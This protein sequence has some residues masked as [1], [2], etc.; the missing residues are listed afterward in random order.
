MIIMACTTCTRDKQK[1]K[2]K[3]DPVEP[4]EAS[5]N[6]NTESDTQDVLCLC[7]EVDPQMSEE[8]PHL[9][10]GIAEELHQALLPRDVQSTEQFITECC[11]VE[12]LRCSIRNKEE[13]ATPMNGG[14]LKESQSVSTA[15]AQVTSSAIAATR[16]DTM[17]RGE[18]NIS[19]ASA[20]GMEVWCHQVSKF[21]GK[22]NGLL[23][24]RVGHWVIFVY[25]DPTGGWERHLESWSNGA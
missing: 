18:M 9:M 22:K 2:R 15:N 8:I 6:V 19:K 21:L 7:K 16:I 11:R 13:Y 10:K 4:E 24:S 14:Q 12:A 23:E 20:F 5:M 25:P 1:K 17:K 3:I